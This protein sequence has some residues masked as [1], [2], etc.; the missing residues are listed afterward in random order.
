MGRL[1]GLSTPSSDEWR[2]EINL[3]EKLLI[4]VHDPAFNSRNNLELD[5]AD[6]RVCSA[7]VLN[8]G[9]LRALQPEVSGR[10]WTKAK[11]DEANRYKVYETPDQYDAVSAAP[12]RSV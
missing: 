9:C 12:G 1:K 10:R 11:T 3:A 6:S 4:H 8:W 7:R 5:E 2:T